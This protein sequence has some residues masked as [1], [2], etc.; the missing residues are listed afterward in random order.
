MC[1]LRAGFELGCTSCLVDVAKDLMHLVLAN[2][3]EAL[4]KLFNFPIDLPP[5]EQTS[6]SHDRNALLPFTPLS[7]LC[8]LRACL[9]VEVVHGWNIRGARNGR[10]GRLPLVHDFTSASDRKDICWYALCY[11]NIVSWWLIVNGRSSR[12][13]MSKFRGWI[14]PR[15]G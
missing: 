12:C 1:I 5:S 7:P 11:R 14:L 8:L 2:G 4:A 9:V 13:G 3:I 6:L 15:E 10:I